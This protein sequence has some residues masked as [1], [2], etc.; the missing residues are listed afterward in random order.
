MLHCGQQFATRSLSLSL[1]LVFGCHG[2]R[3]DALLAYDVAQGG[4]DVR[5]GLDHNGRGHR[6]C[7]ADEV[8][9]QVGKKEKS[10]GALQNGQQLSG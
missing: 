2:P 9:L 6:E 8:L 1:C 5:G 3:F 10:I 7:V 4:R